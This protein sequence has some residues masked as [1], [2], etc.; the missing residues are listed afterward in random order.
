MDV[1]ALN[2][3]VAITS[4][5]FIRVSSFFLTHNARG[6]M[7]KSCS[8]RFLHLF[9]PSHSPYL[10]LHLC[11]YMLMVKAVSICLSFPM[12]HSFKVKDT[13]SREIFL[14]LRCAVLFTKPADSLQS[15]LLIWSASGNNAII[16]RNSCIL[17][18]DN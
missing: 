18:L 4:L 11:F 9:A 1:I 5:L 16:L 13:Q 7:V 12:L 8:S 3:L 14:L 10:H 15:Y 17:L 6:E 2:S